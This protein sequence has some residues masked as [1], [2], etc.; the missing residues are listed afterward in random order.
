MSNYFFIFQKKD[1]P[2]LV[3]VRVEGSILPK[4]EESYMT[5]FLEDIKEQYLDNILSKTSSQIA[6][7]YRKKLNNSKIFFKNQFSYIHQN[8]ANSEDYTHFELKEFTSLLGQIDFLFDERV[9]GNKTNKEL[10]VFKVVV[11]P[12]KLLKIMD[13]S[14]ESASKLN[15]K[16]IDNYDLFIARDK[17]LLYKKNSLLLS[18][19]PENF[20]DI[21]EIIKEREKLSYLLLDIDVDVT[22]SLI[23]LFNLKYL[24]LRDDDLLLTL[25]S[26]KNNVKTV[27]QLL[28]IFKEYEN[29]YLR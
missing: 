21:F 12:D 26:I 5:N 17:E 7:T 23:E 20:K 3:R 16:I 9:Y 27:R 14:I 11:E 6:S 10:D 22:N 28:I 25:E 4:Y 1:S 24:K 13:A 8:I 29:K 2:K 19:K 18:K 15:Q